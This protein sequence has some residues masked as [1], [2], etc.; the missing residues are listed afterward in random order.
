ME[1]ED[2]KN[3]ALY[4]S[5]Q[6]SYL[7]FLESKKSAELDYFDK[8]REYYE[9]HFSGIKDIYL[10]DD[11]D[12]QALLLKKEESEKKYDDKIAAYKTERLKR[13]ARIEEDKLKAEYDL[14]QSK[15]L[16]DELELQEKI[17]KIKVDSLKKQQELYKS[18]SEKWEA[19]QL[20]I[21]QISF[22]SKW[23]RENRLEKALAEMKRMYAGVS[24]SEQFKIELSV[25]Q[26]LLDNEKIKIEDF[27][28]W[29]RELRKKYA[30]DLPGGN[31]EKSRE[32]LQMQRNEAKE[33]QKKQILDAVDSGV[34]SKDEGDRRIRQLDVEEL[35]VFVDAVKSCGSEWVEMLATV[36]DAYKDLWEAIGNDS[37]N[38]L[39]KIAAAAQST[40][41][42]VGS[43]LQMAAEFAQAN[44]QIEIKAIEKR[45]DR[46]IELAQ[47]NSY[48][49]KKLE[50]DKEKATAEIKNK[51]SKA[52]FNMQ[53]IQ[54]IGQAIT[55]ALNAYTSTAAIPIIGPALAPAAAAVAAAAGAAQVVLLKKQQQAAEAQGYAEGGYT[56]PGTKYETA[57]VVHAG[58][59]VASQE[60]LKSPVAGPI[61]A[62]LDA[63]QRAHSDI[64]AIRGIMD[65]VKSENVVTTL[66]KEDASRIV[67]TG[68]ATRTA[69]A[70][71]KSVLEFRQNSAPSMSVTAK[72][73]QN[74]ADIAELR[75]VISKLNKRLEEPFY[76]INSV[77]GPHGMKSAEDEY[78][79]LMNN[80]KRK[81]R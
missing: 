31:F 49:V 81:S 61:I 64:P 52:S 7:E 41:A 59:W 42:V 63:A 46:E 48:L 6:K 2:A 30:A 38:V 60:L 40:F 58:E 3:T 78:N 50:K 74:S 9:K 14:K 43:G 20:E 75:E 10:E 73:S 28:K 62:A 54:A 45:Y 80:L 35:K 36:G 18:G 26:T 56:K 15:T 22:E 23:Q 44:A 57:G 53:V 39:S 67:A 11:K 19:I 37:D 8:A 66:S 17:N 34:I 51:A 68:A 71:E 16:D 5:G 1:A 47:G 32:E 27:E 65:V 4:A 69:A 13:E 77:T 79:R 21:E 29:K 55:G 33:K 12:Y 72:D 70:T 25:L 76:T 24:A